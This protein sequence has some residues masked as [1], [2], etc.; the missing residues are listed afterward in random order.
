MTI[1]PNS[2]KRQKSIQHLSKLGGINKLGC[3]NKLG[4]IN[5]INMNFLKKSK[6]DV[7]WNQFVDIE[8]G[9]TINDNNNKDTTYYVKYIIDTI[10]CYTSKYLYNTNIIYLLSV[11]LYLL[12]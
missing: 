12:I 6:K 2:L 9:E 1:S 10:K 11:I 3:I 4:G 5:N 8:S 7:E